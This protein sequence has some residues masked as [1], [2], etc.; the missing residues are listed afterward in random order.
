MIDF[1]LCLSTLEK[2]RWW[3]G[4]QECGQDWPK[5]SR[6]LDLRG[7]GAQLSNCKITIIPQ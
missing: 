3:I 1:L 4:T 6:Y 7:V 2:R 5:T